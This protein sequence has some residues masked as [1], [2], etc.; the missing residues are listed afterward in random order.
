[1]FRLILLAISGIS[2][3][4][5][6]LFW[7]I[8]GRAYDVVL[9]AALAFL[10][11]N[12]FYIFISRPTVRTS[13]ILVRA[14]SGLALASMELQY[15]AEAAQ[16]REAEAE[17]LRLAEAERNQQKLQVAKEMLQHLRLN[18]PADPK[19]DGNRPQ[20]THQGRSESVALPSPRPG[21]DSV[22][23]SHVRDAAEK[24]MHPATQLK[25]AQPTITLN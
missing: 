18:G 20:I 8:S 11:A 5:L 19:K 17:T 10:I 9:F 13:D 12:A 6:L 25:P 4:G 22:P 24:P 14:S 2:A 16:V 3:L 1:M 7:T 21:P 23:S 15:Q